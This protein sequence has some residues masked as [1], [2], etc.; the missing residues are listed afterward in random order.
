MKTTMNNVD[1]KFMINDLNKYLSFRLLNV[2]ELDSKTIIL[3]LTDKNE[4]IFIKMKSGYHLFATPSKPED[5][6]L[7]PGSFCSKLRKHLNNKRLEKIEQYGL[8]RIIDFH[9]G[10]GEHSYH[11][12]LELYSNGNIILTDKNYN[13]LHL[14]RR[15][16]D[17]E[18]NLILKVNEIYPSEKFRKIEYNKQYFLEWIKQVNIEENKQKSIK[19]LFTRIDSP[20]SKFGPAIIN[21]CLSLLQI[22]GNKKCKI[23]NDLE[24][25]IFN[26]LYDEITTFTQNIWMMDTSKG[27]IISQDSGYSDYIPFKFNH[28]I[29]KELIEFDNFNDCLK[30]YFN[31]FKEGKKNIIEDK[32]KK[33]KL[34]KVDRAIFEVNNRISNFKSKLE[35]NNNQIITI[36]KNIETIS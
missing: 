34:G 23:L 3:K 36:D 7:M 21:H 30:H 17:Q 16:T 18:N 2:Y 25:D 8:D 32:K 1:I 28:Y 35:D 12:I 26:K 29:N 13:I 5:I 4:K 33:E 22:N 6:P 11:I 19:Q 27:Y 10:E 9:F 14:L 15:Y 31:H 24:E 20:L